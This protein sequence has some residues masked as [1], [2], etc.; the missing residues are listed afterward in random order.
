M[1]NNSLPNDLTLIVSLALSED[2]GDGDITSA[3]LA[4]DLKVKANI[5]CKEDAVLCGIPWA[6]EAYEKI[7]NSLQIEW[8]FNEGA[9]IKVGDRVASIIGNARTILSSERTALNF[10][11]TLS[12]TATITA[13][14]IAAL[15]DTSTKLLDTRK[16]IPGLRTAQKYA[17][18]IG[19]GSNHRAGLYDAYLIKEN[20]IKSCGNISNAITEARK[21]NPNKILEVEVQ[22]LEEFREA[23]SLKPNLIMLDNFTLADMK[24]AVS[25]NSGSVKL[26]VSGGVDLESLA[27]IAKTGVDYISVGALTKHCRAIDFSL[28]VE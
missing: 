14:Y 18:K 2:I 16:T 11:Q 21:M 4:K 25:L 22:N 3:L 9:K 8:E 20:H 23:I 1:T 12:G 17:V 6:N 19:G 5:I 7:D 10:L 13:E 28:L 24:K 27:N 26:E 15:Q